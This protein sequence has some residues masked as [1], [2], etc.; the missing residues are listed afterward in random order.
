M[1]AKLLVSASVFFFLFSRLFAM[2]S[3]KEE[4]FP[5]EVTFQDI[6]PRCQKLIT[7]YFPNAKP[8]FY[9]STPP[10]SFFIITS[11]YSFCID[12]M[13][14]SKE[15]KKA[16]YEVHTIFQESCSLFKK[17]KNNEQ[18]KTA[19]YLNDTALHK[20]MGLIINQDKELTGSYNKKLLALYE[21]AMKADE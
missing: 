7:S 16:F 3:E 6:F 1:K 17:S 4:Y 15:C 8:S 20:I 13:T 18:E 14:D 5:K 10:V 21:K 9:N 11:T 12:A 19:I 2:E